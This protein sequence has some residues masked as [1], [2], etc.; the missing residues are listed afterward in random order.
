M[1]NK[2]IMCGKPA[3]ILD[4]LSEGRFCS[5][6]CYDKFYEEWEKGFQEYLKGLKEGKYEN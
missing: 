2:C 5:K 6:E 4:Y 1:K 3:E